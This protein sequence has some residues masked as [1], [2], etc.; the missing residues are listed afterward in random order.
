MQKVALHEP[1]LIDYGKSCALQEALAAELISRKLK[2]RKGRTE[3]AEAPLHHLILCQH[4]HVYTLGKSGSK[5]NLL[6][7][8]AALL[9]KGVQF[10]HIN[11]GGDITYH[12]P[13][14]LVG[15]P[16]LD[17]DCF[18]TDVHKYLRSIEEAVIC[19]L[20]DFD[21]NASRYPGFTGV[22]LDAHD[23]QQARKVCAIGVHMS[24]W[25]TTHG[26][27]LN[28]NT[29]LSYFNS[30]VPC[31]IKGKKVTSMQQELGKSVNIEIVGER[32]KHH[33]SE[34]FKLEF[35]NA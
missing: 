16:I 34:I 33:L 8:E 28:V 29:D 9:E 2:T 7:S 21:I 15:Y 22:W 12:G 3:N 17:L 5:D 20:G 18:F 26:F 14:Q 31:G 30:I 6:I 35:V 25:V 11:R 13:G 27:A 1:G 23:P 19:T 24:R 10:H 4:P 32:I